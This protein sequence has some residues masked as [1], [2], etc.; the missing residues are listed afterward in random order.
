MCIRDSHYERAFGN[1]DSMS[2]SQRGEYFEIVSDNNFFNYEQQ[3]YAFPELEAP[4]D[5]V[6]HYLP[7]PRKTAKSKKRKKVK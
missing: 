1:Y 3:E 7:T 6:E 2:F 5:T 4:E